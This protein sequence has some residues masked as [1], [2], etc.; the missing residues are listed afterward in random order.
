LAACVFTCS[1]ASA[2]FGIGPLLGLNISDYRQ[3]MEGIEH[4]NLVKLGGRIGMLFE[5]P[6]NQHLYLQ[7]GIN[8]VT[9]GYKG[10]YANADIL[11]VINTIEIPLNLEYKL[12][13]ECS[14]R[15]FFG[16]GPYFGLVKDGFIHLTSGI[17]VDSR[18]DLYIGP[19]V[20]DDVKRWD[21][22]F[23]L[24]IGCELK[25]A[26][27]GRVHYQQGFRNVLPLGNDANSLYNYNCG[28]SVAYLFHVKHQIKHKVKRKHEEEKAKVKAKEDQDGDQKIKAKHKDK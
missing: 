14:N 18:R 16:G 19:A 17:N 28:L 25:G 8:Y 2:Q 21:A 24:N 9:N 12:G 10:N 3:T 26:L 11:F 13:N 4:K 5:N 27:I 7:P 20:S 23:G 22:G 1:T 15:F 6:F